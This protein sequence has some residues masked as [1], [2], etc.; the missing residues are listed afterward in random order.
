MN[1]ILSAQIRQYYKAIF[2]WHKENG[3]VTI[4]RIIKANQTWG[5]NND[6]V[7]EYK[8]A[9]EEMPHPEKATLYEMYFVAE[10]V[11]SG[12]L[13]WNY[14][15][16]N[17]EDISLGDIANK[18][19]ELY[20]EAKNVKDAKESE[21]TI[22]IVIDHDI[23]NDNEYFR[24]ADVVYKNILLNN[25]KNI[26]GRVAV[27][28]TN[29]EF[30]RLSGKESYKFRRPEYLNFEE[31]PQGSIYDLVLNGHITVHEVNAKK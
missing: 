24:K 12:I 11:R 7:N 6:N 30:E 15:E 8:S 3:D 13:E 1:D 14:T 2:Y 16:K 27:A 19:I 23:Q 9:L 31:L 28:D 22:F 20:K 29:L 18:I 25:E 5:R 4:E 10:K 21:N 26:G 17:H